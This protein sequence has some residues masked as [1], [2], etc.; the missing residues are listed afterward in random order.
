MVEHWR[1]G[2]G[3]ADQ[4]R[5]LMVKG[6]RQMETQVADV[7]ESW[8][9]KLNLDQLLKG[10]DPLPWWVGLSLIVLGMSMPSTRRALR[11]MIAVG[12]HVALWAMAIVIALAGIFASLI[13]WAGPRLAAWGGNWLHAMLGG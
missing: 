6:G 7:G 9:S 3:V 2:H 1:A 4:M 8:L 10:D 11:R 5:A 13:A 12:F